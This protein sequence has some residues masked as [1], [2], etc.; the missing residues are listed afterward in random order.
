MA[1]RKVLNIINYHRHANL[2]QNEISPTLVEMYP[3]SKRQELTNT[4]E[5][6]ERNSAALLM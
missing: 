6:K 5:D 2:N 4:G 3:S 1:N